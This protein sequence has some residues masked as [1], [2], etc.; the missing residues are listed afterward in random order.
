[1]AMTQFYNNYQPVLYN[2]QQ[3]QCGWSVLGMDASS[4]LRI[5]LMQ[6]FDIITP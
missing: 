3:R 5:E 4:M 1:V 2:S 6:I